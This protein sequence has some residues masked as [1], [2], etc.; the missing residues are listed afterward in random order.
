MA[1]CRAHYFTLFPVLLGPPTTRTAFSK[2]LRLFHWNE[3]SCCS[4]SPGYNGKLKSA[5]R[6]CTYMYV[7]YR[8]GNNSQ[9]SGIF[10]LL[11]DQRTILVCHYVGIFYTL[12]MLIRYTHGTYM[13]MYVHVYIVYYKLFNVRTMAEQ[14]YYAQTNFRNIFLVTYF[15]LTATSKWSHFIEYAIS[16]SCFW[17]RAIISRMWWQA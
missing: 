7:C 12:H 1:P 4:W 13:Y 15:Q 16:F 14:I 5:T 8:V 2:S 10:L 17:Y 6:T 9:T 11:S 3:A